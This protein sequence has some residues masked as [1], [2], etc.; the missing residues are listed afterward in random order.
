M[1]THTLETPG[2]QSFE[3]VATIAVCLE[4]MAMVDKSLENN[5]GHQMM[6]V[7]E[8][9]DALLD[10]RGVVSKLLA[11]MPKL[12]APYNDTCDHEYDSYCPKC[13]IDSPEEYVKQ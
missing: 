7:S 12:P 8:V 4:V 3:A 1:S 9:A 6:P 13:G 11:Q 5:A 10:I 2:P